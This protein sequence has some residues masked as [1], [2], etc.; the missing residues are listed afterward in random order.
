MAEYSGLKRKDIDERDKLITLVQTQSDEINQLKN[1][2]E[3]LIRKPMR[4]LPAIRRGPSFRKS[5]GGVGDQIQ[6]TMMHG[7]S[8]PGFMV[9]NSFAEEAGVAAAADMVPI[10]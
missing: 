10:Q 2:I 9:E 1:E 5:G 8:H 6:T 4:Q 3:I 7:G